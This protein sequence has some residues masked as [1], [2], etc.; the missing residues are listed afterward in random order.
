MELLEIL[1]LVSLTPYTVTELGFFTY[2]DN[3]FLN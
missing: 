2:I 1:Y 3:F